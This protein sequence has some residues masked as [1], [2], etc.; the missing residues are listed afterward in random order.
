MTTTDPGIDPEIEDV[1]P[2][3]PLQEGILFH[4]LA[5]GDGT[6]VYTVQ[7]V[8][9]LEAENEADNEAMEKKNP[10]DDEVEELEDDEFDE[11]EN[12]DMARS[13]I[14]ASQ[15]TRGGSDALSVES[16]HRCNGKRRDGGKQECA[17]EN[18]DRF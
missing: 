7:S 16:N 3:S 2:L 5:A 17:D 18:S 9:H 14:S 1:L 15:S 8:F 13:R 4:T 10:E 6:D 11:D 12:D